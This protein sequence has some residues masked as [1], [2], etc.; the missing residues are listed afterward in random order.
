MGT[1]H[2]QDST[3]S[4]GPGAGAANSTQAGPFMLKAALEVAMSTP[5]PPWGPESQG[6]EAGPE[7]RSISLPLSA[8]AF[9]PCLAVPW[10]EI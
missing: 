5:L 4:L 3:G 9:P 10:G 8:L 1:G 7:D 2:S 6:K